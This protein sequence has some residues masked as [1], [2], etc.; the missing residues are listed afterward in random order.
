MIII[1]NSQNISSTIIYGAHLADSMELTNMQTNEDFSI[2]LFDASPEARFGIF[3]FIYDESIPL[4]SGEVI[5]GIV[6]FNLVPGKYIYNVNNLSGILYFK[7]LK[8]NVIIYD[9]TNESTIYKG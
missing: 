4:N 8:N 1:D 6:H 3:Q 7:E 5:E 2:P 9:Q